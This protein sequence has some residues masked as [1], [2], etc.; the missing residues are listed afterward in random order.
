MKRKPLISIDEQMY[1]AGI[2]KRP[3]LFEIPFPGITF[4]VE[5]KPIGKGTM[6][7][8]IEEKP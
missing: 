8:R 4:C 5:G 3:V 7:W 2:W 1:R 6:I